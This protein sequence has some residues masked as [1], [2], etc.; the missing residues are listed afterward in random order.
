MFLNHVRLQ[1]TQCPLLPLVMGRGILADHWSTISSLSC[2]LC[3]KCALSFYTSTQ[4]HPEM[5]DIFLIFGGIALIHYHH[6]AVISSLNVQIKFLEQ[7]PSHTAEHI[8]HV[9]ITFAQ[10]LWVLSPYQYKYFSTVNWLW[11]GFTTTVVQYCNIWMAPFTNADWISVAVT[12]CTSPWY[13][14]YSATI[15]DEFLI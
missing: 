5:N 12:A 3:L 2:N 6:R 15:D 7:L 4:M 9:C 8:N 13:V 1:S 10:L 14:S 11:Q